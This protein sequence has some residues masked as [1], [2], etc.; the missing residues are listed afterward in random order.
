MEVVWIFMLRSTSIGLVILGRNLHGTKH[1]RDDYLL[2]YIYIYIYYFWMFTKFII[3][4]QNICLILHIY[5]YIYI[6]ECLGNLN[7]ESEP[8]VYKDLFH[9]PF[10]KAVW[11][12]SRRCRQ[13]NSEYFLFMLKFEHLLNSK[14]PP[15]EARFSVCSYVHVY[16][17]I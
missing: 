8:R 2:L 7:W 4:W 1:K 11:C 15:T 13:T 10:R 12:P 14:F 16:I 6:D 9:F 17:Y 5:I 3:L